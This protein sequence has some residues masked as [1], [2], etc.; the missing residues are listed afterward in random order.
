MLPPEYLQPPAGFRGRVVLY[1]PVAHHAARARLHEEFDR[2]RTGSAVVSFGD[3]PA[4]GAASPDRLA[5]RFACELDGA[6][7]GYLFAWER[8]GDV[9]EFEA[10]VEIGECAYDLGCPGAL[11]ALMTV[12]LREAFARGAKRVTARLPFDDRV[13]AALRQAGVPFQCV[14]LH[15]GLA[16]NMIRVVD[17][18]ELLRRIAPELEARLAAS[19]F[20]G[21]RGEVA[22]CLSGEPPIVLEVRRGS[23]G[24]WQ[25]TP[26]AFRVDLDQAAM[27]SLVLGLRSFGECAAVRGHGDTRTAH[28]VCEALFPAQPTASGAWG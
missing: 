5:L 13:R 4:A 1:D 20:A 16:S 26:G 28:A 27:L 6:L 10:K 24:V 15:S 21:W 12:V 17:P 11:G 9:T 14:E 3:P 23:V 22:F 18:P 19:P 2:E 7:V 8:E 25:Q